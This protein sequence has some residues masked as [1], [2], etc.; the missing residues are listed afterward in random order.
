MVSV[1]LFD[2]SGSE[3]R[4]QCHSTVR[5][6]VRSRMTDLVH[7]L[8]GLRLHVSR[9]E[10]SLASENHEALCTYVCVCAWGW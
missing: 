9:L 7:P 4:C 2:T 3:V 1:V 8:H 6:C 5:R 10:D